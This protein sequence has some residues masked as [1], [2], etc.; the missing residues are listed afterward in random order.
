MRSILALVVVAAC[1]GGRSVP[2]APCLDCFDAAEDAH[3]DPCV[4]RQRACANGDKCT[5]IGPSRDRACVSATGSGALGAACTGSD[6]SDDCADG[7]YCSTLGGTAPT[8]HA[9]CQLDTDCLTGEACIALD[10][11]HLIDGV[12]T[13]T[14]APFG[15]SCGAQQTCAGAYDETGTAPIAWVCRGVGATALGGACTSHDDCGA[16]ALCT[17]AGPSGEIECAPICDAAHPCAT[18]HCVAEG[19]AG[20]CFQH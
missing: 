9:L 16:G 19:A 8:C 17:N 6:G 11:A 3:V 14:C 15:S 1:G 4:P 12:C 7:L 10:G 20:V 13:A 18:G 2:D 5:V